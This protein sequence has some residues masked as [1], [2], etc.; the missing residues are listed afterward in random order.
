MPLA[1]LDFDEVAVEQATAEGLRPDVLLL[2]R[3]LP[4]LGIEVLVTHPV[5]AAK[6]GKAT[7]P[8]V[9]LD[10]GKVLASP[11][12][13]KPSQSAHPWTAQCQV[14][15]CIGAAE[16][17]GLS[18]VTGPADYVSQLAA[19]GFHRRVQAWLQSGHRRLKPSVCWRCPACRKR[20]V[21]PLCRNRVHGATLASSLAPTIHPQV[22]LQVEAGQF[23]F[24]IF[25][26]PANPRRPWSIINLTDRGRPILRV[27]PD[28]KRPHQLSL[29]GTN[30]PFAFLCLRCGSDCLGLFPPPLP[31]YW[32]AQME[33]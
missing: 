17:A 6:A 24:I 31:C 19:S 23:V 1:D 9:E 21:R 15:S 10:A 11:R 20:N 16:A 13:W 14:C 27:T 18:E 22:I 7:F 28:L 32:K 3:G 25:G 4:A 5:D 12:S 30:R 33:P 26:F 2:R 29:N 8:W